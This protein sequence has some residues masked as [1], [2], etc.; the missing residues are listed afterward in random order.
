MRAGVAA[1]VV[2]VLATVVLAAAGCGEGAVDCSKVMLTVD[3][4]AVLSTLSAQD[5]GNVCDYGAC[6][7]GGYGAKVYCTDGTGIVT[8][9]TGRQQCIN[10]TTSN[11]TCT[12]TVDDLLRCTEA[13]RQSPCT[14]TL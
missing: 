3:R 9:T 12:A 11:P 10:N 14:S 2:A 8:L 6:Q 5:K 4:S 7:L 1:W 13:L